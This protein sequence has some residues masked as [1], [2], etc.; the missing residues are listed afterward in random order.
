[1]PRLLGRRL[2]LGLLV[3]LSIAPLRAQLTFTF[4]Y[5][6][7]NGFFSGANDW[8]R[9]YLEAAGSY[10]SQYF[11]AT[12]L[13][14]IA[15]QNGNSWSAKVTNPNNALDFKEFFSV[16]ANNVIVVVG[17]SS[18]NALA[19]AAPANYSVSGEPSWVNS[20]EWRATSVVTYKR[21]S[22]G[23]LYFN[24][25]TPWF[26]DSTPLSQKLF[27]QYDFFS[28]ATH[29][30]L[31]VLGFGQPGF[32]YGWSA[33]LFGPSSFAGGRVLD[34]TDDVPVPL[35]ADK[36]HWA[37][38]TL[39]FS[40]RDGTS[41]ETLMDPDIAAGVRKYLTTL[42]LRAMQDIGYPANFT[43]VPEPAAFGVGAGVI[44]LVWAWRRRRAQS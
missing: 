12:T 4:D 41:Q 39:S 7:D 9:P 38:G 40:M 23:S 34:E 36:G 21:T 19:Q 25:S 20:V 24:T 35:T 6:L 33:K 29:E 10:V 22:V 14:E 27:S 16:P 30:L 15:P 13:A 1:M 17:G 5:T 3:L 37:A 11:T 28:V 31:H 43:A 42:D 18:I 26:F 32:G 8:R 44:S 2:A